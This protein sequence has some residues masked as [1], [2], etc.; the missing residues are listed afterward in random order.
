MV[1]PWLLGF[2]LFTAGPMVA[3][4][5]L[6]FTN[7]DIL[8]DPRWIGAANYQRLANDDVVRVTLTNTAIFTA[9][10][11]PAQL[12]TALGLALLLNMP[13]RGIGLFRTFYYLPSVVPAIASAL[14]WILV[15]E[16]GFRTRQWFLCARSM[17]RDRLADRSGLRR[18]RRWR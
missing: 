5:V 14:V 18:N 10:V 4:L 17:C 7:F 15:L 12:V 2:V 16:S 6:S 11:V 1:S 9:M 8:S 3:S 13:L